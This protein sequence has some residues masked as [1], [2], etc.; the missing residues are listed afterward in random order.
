[1]K[2]LEEVQAVIRALQQVDFS[3]EL[4]WFVAED[5]EIRA[6]VNCSDVFCWATADG[7]CVEVADIPLL[8]Q[9]N[10]DLEAIS[11]VNKYKNLEAL[12]AARKRG[13]RPQDYA[14]PHAP[15]ELLALYEACGPVRSNDFN[16]PACGD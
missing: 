2:T 9:A 10:A 7:E 1:M 14:I 6:Q 11:G 13:M 3:D 5:G 4:Y 16:N 8:L 12:F 15:S